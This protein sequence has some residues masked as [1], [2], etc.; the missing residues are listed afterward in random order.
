[1]K[2]TF[3]II[4]AFI[5]GTTAYS[6]ITSGDDVQGREGS[7][8]VQTA[9]PFM[10]IAPDARAAA[11]GDVG[12]ATTPDVNSMH[13]NPA[14]LTFI[15][16]EDGN[17]SNAGVSFSYTPWLRKLI[18]DM[19]LNQLSAYKRLRKE[20][21]V[22][23][24]MNYFDL[25]QM[26]F[27]DEQNVVTGERRPYELS[28]NVAYSRKLS[29]HL[30]IGV[31]LKWIHSNLA[32]GVVLSSGDQARAGN[33]V[34][35]DIGGYWNKDIRVSGE[36]FNLGLGAS[37]TNLGSKMTYTTR[38]Q[39]FFIPTNLRIGGALTKDIDLF[40]KITLAVDVNKL[41]VPTP[42]QYVVNSAGGDS[43]DASGNRVVFAGQEAQ[44]RSLI[45]G[46]FGSFA[47]APGGFSEEL[48]EFTVST[49]LEYWYAD[50][51]AARAGY[52]YEAE[53]KGNRKF[54]TLGAGV[55][56]KQYGLDFAYLIP[57]R[58]AN[59]LADTIR[60]S[61]LANFK[62]KKLGEPEGIQSGS[63]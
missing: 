61:L 59:P 34:A 62:S 33:S 38:E 9:V 40:N 30:S 15:E 8:F 17:L 41:M 48:S 3:L 29:E 28:L 1:M 21:V 16:D 31:G 39:A 32:S 43:T 55:R 35:A 60:F 25:G 36:A 53:S 11:M 19:S 12:A 49:A 37:I 52:F 22:G 7:R 14:K 24:S 20:E 10:T 44:G 18:D 58:Q 13:W 2:K 6:Q 23:V 27:R 42:A 57:I 45:S 5:C 51:F 63:N 50:A 4:S 46:V 54:F 26:T 56:W 47:D